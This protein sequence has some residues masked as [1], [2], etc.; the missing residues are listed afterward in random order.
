MADG[1]RLRADWSFTLD[2]EHGEN[3]MLCTTAML[4]RVPYSDGNGIEREANGFEML[5][6]VYDITDVREKRYRAFIVNHGTGILFQQPKIDN[7]FVANT[8]RH[9]MD[10]SG[11]IRNAQSFNAMRASVTRSLMKHANST[12]PIMMATN[13]LYHMPNGMRATNEN[14]SGNTQNNEIKSNEDIVQCIVQGLPLY[15]AKVW[16]TAGIAGET[17]DLTTGRNVNE[18]SSRVDDLLAHA[19]QGLRLEAQQFANQAPNNQQANNT[20]ATPTPVQSFFA[21]HANQQQQQSFSSP[22]S[23]VFGSGF[24]AT[25]TQ[26]FGNVAS[27]NH[28]GNNTNSTAQPQFASPQGQPQPP[29]GTPTQPP[30]GTPTQPPFGSPS[31]NSA[32]QNGA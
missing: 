2:L 23:G 32:G 27:A 19:V 4:T 21:P 6:K 26:G 22:N 25:Q 16:F 31:Q 13:V 20:T 12:E 8:D 5:F 14:F 24:Q 11:H 1:T 18:V 10:R 29:F 17:T 30:F 3:N 7:T 9:F 15:Y 28:F